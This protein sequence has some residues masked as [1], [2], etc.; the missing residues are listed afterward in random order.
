VICDVPSS[1]SSRSLPWD[2]RLNT[3]AERGRKLIGMKNLQCVGGALKRPGEHQT[4]P[5]GFEN[6]QYLLSFPPW[7]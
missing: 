3:S 7:P 2:I 6:T 5:E 4:Q 1:E